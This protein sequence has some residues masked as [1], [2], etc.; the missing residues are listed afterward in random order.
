MVVNLSGETVHGP[1]KTKLD[2]LIRCICQLLYSLD[3]V[4]ENFLFVEA[5]LTTL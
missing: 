4:T 3:E 5:F 1:I 2:K